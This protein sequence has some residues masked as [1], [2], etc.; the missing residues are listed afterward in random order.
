MAR[1]LM[2]SI[3]VLKSV[4]EISAFA[5]AVPVTIL[6]RQR[7]SQSPELSVRSNIPPAAIID[8][9]VVPTE[10]IPVFAR[11][12]C[13]MAGDNASLVSLIIERDVAQYLEA[14]SSTGTPSVVTPKW[15]FG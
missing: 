9:T 10:L 13:G 14:I 6:F 4:C 5:V 1:E 15:P 11:I 12:R 2:A 3:K 8:A 7:I